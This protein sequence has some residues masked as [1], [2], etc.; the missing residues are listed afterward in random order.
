MMIVRG[1]IQ[2][3][4]SPKEDG[5]GCKRNFSKT[6]QKASHFTTNSGLFFVC[7]STKK[8]T[9]THRALKVFIQLY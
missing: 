7:S 1:I 8:C 5:R 4:Y 6:H 9:H 2:S 3:A